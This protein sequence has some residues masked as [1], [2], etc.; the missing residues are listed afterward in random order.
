M[1]ANSQSKVIASGFTIIRPDDQPNIR[2]K[3]KDNNHKDWHT[4]EKFKTKAARD[5]KMSE[6]LKSQLIISD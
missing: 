2:I 3:C 1:D 6:L 5:R 4:L